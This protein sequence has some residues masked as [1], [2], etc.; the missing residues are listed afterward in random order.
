VNKE[1]V[2]KKR[3][4]ECNANTESIVEFVK[5]KIKGECEILVYI[6]HFE[7]LGN[8]DSDFDVYVLSQKKYDNLVEMVKLENIKCDIEYWS[9]DDIKKLVDE[10]HCMDFVRIKALKKMTTAIS[11]YHGDDKMDELLVL[12]NSVDIDEMA[13]MYFK[14]ILNAEY[15]DAVKMFKNKEWIACHSCCY[16]AVNAWL[17][18]VNQKNNFGNMNLKWANKIFVDHN[19]FDTGLLDDYLNT[20]VYVNISKENLPQKVED[21]MCFLG[22]N[23]NSTLF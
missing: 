8:K 3:L 15:D 22:D 10:I 11:I 12:L 23:K 14:S 5:K 13:Y 1:E 19:G 7:G 4:D 18:T 20:F 6:S 16:R 17:A 9:Y 2:L 21:M